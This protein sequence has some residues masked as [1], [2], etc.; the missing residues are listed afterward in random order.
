MAIL[1]VIFIY[2]IMVAQFQNLLSP[3]IIMFTL[4][5]AFTGG[6]LLLWISGLVSPCR[7][8]WAFSPWP[9]SWSTMGLSLLIMSTNCAW[10]ARRK[11]EALLETGA[12]LRPILMT[13]D[14]YPAH[15]HDCPGM[16]SGVEMTQ[17]WQR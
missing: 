6:L 9:G 14:H 5:L 15:E 4:P 10:R 17:P 7:H 13:A 16:G 1:A 3:F 8:C 12:R 11:R 2:L